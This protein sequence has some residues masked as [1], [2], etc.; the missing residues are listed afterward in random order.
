MA[1]EELGLKGDGA[2]RK[3]I[4]A[5]D[6][7]MNALL[8]ARTKRMKFGKEEKE[9]GAVVVSLYKKHSLR[10]YNFDDKVYDLKAVEKV[11]VHKDDADDDE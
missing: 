8:S 6:E 2:E 7:A 1:N 11:V 10:A 5:L 9:A 4:K 3:T